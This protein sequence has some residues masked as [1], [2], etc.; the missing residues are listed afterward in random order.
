VLLGCNASSS[1]QHDVELKQQ[2]APSIELCV[3]R[4][5]RFG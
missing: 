2:T 5:Y 4:R 3:G 1:D